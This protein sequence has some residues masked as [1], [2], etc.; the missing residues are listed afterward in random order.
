[1]VQRSHACRSWLAL[2]PTAPN[3]LPIPFQ[4]LRSATSHPVALRG[5]LPTHL[6]MWCSV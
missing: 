6:L 3:N 5:V 4:G 1:M 2:L